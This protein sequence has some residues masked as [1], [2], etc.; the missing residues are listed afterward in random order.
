MQVT[1]SSILDHNLSRVTK[2]RKNVMST[3]YAW[4]AGNL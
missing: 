3:L 1:A 4:T 2:I